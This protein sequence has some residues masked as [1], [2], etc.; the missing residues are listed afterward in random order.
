MLCILLYESNY[1]T[2]GGFWYQ[3]PSW[4][5]D[6]SHRCTVLMYV[7]ITCIRVKVNILRVKGLN[8]N[9]KCHL[10]KIKET[11]M[12]QQC[13]CLW[14]R[15]P[16]VWQR[17]WEK[18]PSLLD[19]YWSEECNGGGISPIDGLYHRGFNVVFLPPESFRHF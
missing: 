19:S 10:F 6:W 18:R 7:Y 14:K 4:P 3:K 2:L 16:V 8:N 13:P 1:G 12:P 9:N 15:V 17:W 11:L 5:L